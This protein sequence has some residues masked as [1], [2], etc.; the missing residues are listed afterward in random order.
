MDQQGRK[1]VCAIG[2]DPGE[3]NYWCRRS[4]RL[5][6]RYR[7]PPERSGGLPPPVDC[8]I[9]G[10][11]ITGL[12]AA[13]ALR[14][15]GASVALFEAQTAGWGASSRNGGMVLTGLKRSLTD[16]IARYGREQAHRLF[17]ASVEAV[18]VVER[19]VQEEG[20]D[21][22]FHREGHLAAACKPTHYEALKRRQE[23]LYQEL[24]YETTLVPRCD[25]PA[26][27]RTDSYHGGLVDRRSAGLDPARYTA[28]L[29]AAAARRG[30]RICEGTTVR[31]VERR[32]GGFAL[33]TTRGPVRA[34]QVL[35]ATNAYTG[36]HAPHLAPWLR[37]RLIPI[38]S[39]IIATEPLGEH[40]ARRL[41]PHGRMVFDTKNM[42]FYFRRTPDHRILFG[43]RASF[44]PASS[45]TTSR[46]LRQGMVGVFPELAAA[47]IEH[48][49]SGLVGFTF[50]LEP[51]I[52]EDRGLHYA[53]GYCGHG[54]AL[55]TYLGERVANLLAGRP[56]DTPFLALPFPSPPA[57]RGRPWFLPLAGA[58]FRALD[59]IR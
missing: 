5:G 30:V 32:P 55:A 38:G 24:G 2:S 18:D 34:A 13:R 23:V 1:S 50:D 7:I 10:G 26:E 49:W 33:V 48:A 20:I 44:T 47:R 4:A 35:I 12:T 42:L 58:Y 37:R 57:Y 25:L 15:L 41:I 31:S 3:S 19:I 59:L 17:L 36:Y 43:G 16:M 14:L 29:A 54:V 53:A 27:L 22:D 56:E 8:A 28:G 45:R 6:D 9:V 51:H 40:T 52:G 21:C 11:G 39:H 46:I